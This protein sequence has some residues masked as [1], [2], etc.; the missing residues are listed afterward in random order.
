MKQRYEAGDV[1]WDDPLPPPEVMDMVAKLPAGRALDLGC[2][3]GRSA[4]YLARHGWQVDAVDF[5]PAAIAEA[6][7]RAKVAGVAGRIRFHVAS[8][9]ELGFLEPF[10]DLAIDVGCLHALTDED[11]VGYRNGLVRLLPAGSWYLL[12]ARLRSPETAVSQT[13][14][15]NSPRGITRDTVLEL[16]GQEFTLVKAT[17]GITHVPDGPSWASG[18]FWW[19]R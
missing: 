8:V 6:R 19:Q 15:T 16:F 10:Y 11:R 14:E 3:Y 4:I 2:G 18:W 12:F 17:E 1:P 5:I 7:R 13:D 9:A